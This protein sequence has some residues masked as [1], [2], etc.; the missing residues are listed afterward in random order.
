MYLFAQDIKAPS[1]T[2][3]VETR[4]SKDQVPSPVREAFLKD[5]GEGHKPLVWVNDNSVFQAEADKEM[6][7][8]QYT[9]KSKASNGSRLFVNYSPDGKR[10]NS[11]EYLK[12]FTPGEAVVNTLRNSEY[13]DWA[14][15]KNIIIRKVSNGGSEL[16]RSYVTLK[17]GKE[18]KTL[19]F[20]EN[21]R[22]VSETKEDLAEADQ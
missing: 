5:Y 18:R 9:L 4:M 12:N 10:M 8:Y 16:E 22:L 19:C 17:K 15:K 2:S 14:L 21:G 1:K 20:D 7:V 13:K 11:R 6:K 3:A